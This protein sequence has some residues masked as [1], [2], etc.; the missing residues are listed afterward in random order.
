MI[1][2]KLNNFFIFLVYMQIMLCTIEI[3]IIA[4]PS[5][6]PPNTPMQSTPSKTPPA[7][8]P[9][10]T[11]FNTHEHHICNPRFAREPFTR[12]VKRNS[13]QMCVVRTSRVP[14]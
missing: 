1:P 7:T 6:E 10:S 2:A 9:A 14:Q 8:Q 11:H 3:I 13:Q 5:D 4:D 12:R